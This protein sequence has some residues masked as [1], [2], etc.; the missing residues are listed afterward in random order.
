MPPPHFRE[1][2]CESV[3]QEAEDRSCT[4][5]V[6]HDV[7][8]DLLHYVITATAST[9]YPFSLTISST[10]PFSENAINKY[11]YDLPIFSIH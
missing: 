9:N 8:H 4:T 7:K 3:V 11:N 5:L 1:G 10:F 6:V 2:L